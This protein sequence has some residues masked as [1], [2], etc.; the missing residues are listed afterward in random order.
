MATTYSIYSG[1]LS[2]PS[3]EA[4]DNPVAALSLARSWG[5]S[6]FV[7][8]RSPGHGPPRVVWTPEIDRRCVGSLHEA[9]IRRAIAAGNG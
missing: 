1:T 6:A 5:P 4:T 9:V 7:T 8:E 3:E 2:G